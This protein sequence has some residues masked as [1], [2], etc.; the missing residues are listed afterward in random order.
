MQIAVVYLND[1]AHFTKR[2]IV[3]TWDLAE[4]DNVRGGSAWSPNIFY[5]ESEEL[6]Y[7]FFAAEPMDRDTRCIY[8]VTSDSPYGPFTHNGPLK[9]I[10]DSPKE[11]DGHPFVGYDGKTYMSYSR[12]DMGGTI[13][14]D[15]VI[16]KDGEVT[17]VP[18]TLTRVII[19]DREWDNDGGHR[20][21]EGG[22]IWK[23]NGYYYLIYATVKY[24]RHY[25]EAVAVS[26]NPLGPYEKYDY[27]PILTHNFTLDGPGDAL[28][29]PSSDGEELYMV[30]HRHNEVGKVSPR[31][32]CVDLIEFVPDPDGGPDI[33]TVRGPSSTPQKLPS[34]K[35]RL[36]V[37]RDGVVSLADA[38]TVLVQINSGEDYCGYYDVDANGSI[39]V[40]DYIAILKNLL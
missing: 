15:E 29:I 6:F 7:I 36:D 5:N 32:V 20:L 30:Y 2:N 13:W 10:H 25:G 18:G 23:H 17:A 22:F 35:Y 3:F 24:E 37:N 19:P 4:Y 21:C 9:A 40:G 38:L 14:F 16:I 31:Q 11:I 8:Y 33:L 39:G 34:N 27:N 1:L 26:K 12:Y 28:I